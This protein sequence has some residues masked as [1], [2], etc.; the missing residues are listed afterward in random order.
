MFDLVS[1]QLNPEGHWGFLYHK[2]NLFSMPKKLFSLKTSFLH[3][4]TKEWKKKGRGGVEDQ[5]RS[6]VGKYETPLK[7][8]A[9][10][11]GGRNVPE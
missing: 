10:V 7:L 8:I 9:Q 11:K 3:D 2:Q 5:Q 6:A 4:K 1:M